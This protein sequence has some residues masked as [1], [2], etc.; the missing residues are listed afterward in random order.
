MVDVDVVGYYADE[1]VL[2]VY[3]THRN[4]SVYTPVTC[5]IP[6]AAFLRQWW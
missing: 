1:R 3:L 6:G 5:P 2:E 4:A